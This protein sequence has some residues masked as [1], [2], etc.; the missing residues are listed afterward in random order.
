[1]LPSLSFILTSPLY[2]SHTPL[3]TIPQCLVSPK[4]P[5]L[6]TK[7]MFSS[8]IGTAKSRVAFANSMFSLALA[9]KSFC[10]SSSKEV[11][12]PPGVEEVG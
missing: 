10:V 1:M 2:T 5:K 7:S 8:K 11:E 3:F 4:L 12:I 6:S 9:N